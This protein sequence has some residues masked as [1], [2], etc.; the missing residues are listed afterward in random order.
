MTLPPGFY[1]T[2]HE[3]AAPDAHRL[4]LDWG[5]NPSGTRLT[6][7]DCERLHA[8]LVAKRINVSALLAELRERTRRRAIEWEQRKAAEKAAKKMNRE[9]AKEAARR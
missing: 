2:L 7:R 1:E 6:L 3:L 8:K 4:R 9:A 5:M